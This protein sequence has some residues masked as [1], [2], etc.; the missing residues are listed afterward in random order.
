MSELAVREAVQQLQALELGF[1]LI[2]ESAWSAAGAN[3]EPACVEFLVAR[4]AL[5]DDGKT[6][7]DILPSQA[8]ELAVRYRVVDDDNPIMEEA[9]RGATVAS[10]EFLTYL[11]LHDDDAD[12]LRALVVEGAVDLRW[13]RSW[14]EARAPH[15]LEQWETLLDEA[16]S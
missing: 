15:L 7:R 12:E 5:E 11:A 3:L 10:I 13:V 8:Q 9:L 4:E 16:Y 2:G 1:V 14:I 6:L